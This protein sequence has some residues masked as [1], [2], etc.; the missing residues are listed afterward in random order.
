M[1]AVLNRNFKVK[2]NINC[3]FSP[4]GVV[5]TMHIANI[6]IQL[7][8]KT[9]MQVVLL[10]KSLTN[11]DGDFVVEFEVDSPV[12]YIVDGKI[13]DVFLR[14]FY[15]GEELTFNSLL[16]NIVAYWK[17]DEFSGIS[18]E[19]ATGNGH[20][21][22][23]SGSTLPTWDPGKINNGLYINGDAAGSGDSL[24]LIHI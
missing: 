21:G 7:W 15:N 20:T 10:G 23:L 6:E 22:T 9:P 14:A 12:S 4:E 5:E 13:S 2:G 17:L 16:N 18:A 19:D 8:H 11:A 24:S 3:F 1:D